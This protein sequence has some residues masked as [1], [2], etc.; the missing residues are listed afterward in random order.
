[1]RFPFFRRKAENSPGCHIIS[2]QSSRLENG[3][4]FSLTKGSEPVSIPLKLSLEEFRQQTE[5][6][7][8]ELLEDLWYE[9]WLGEDCSGY[10]LPYHYLYQLD[11]RTR[12]LLHLPEESS[13]LQ[14]ALGNE[15][16]IP[17]ASFRFILEK[18]YGSWKHLEKTA[19]QHGPLITLPDG[20]EILM[21]EQQYAFDRFLANPPLFAENQDLLRHVAQ[22][23]SKAKQLG[24][25]C[26]R[27]LA[28]QDYLFVDDLELEAEFNG[29][30]IKLKPRYKTIDPVPEEIL[31]EMEESSSGFALG[32][33][34]QKIFTHPKVQAEAQTIRQLPV[35]Q[36]TDI[37][38]FTE[39][40]D[41]YLPELEKIDL[42]R[43]G[44][45]VKE[46]G[47][48]IYRAQPFVNASKNK[49]NWFELSAGF[50]T[51][52][53]TGK[54]FEDLPAQELE[55]LIQQARK[56][57]EEYV[58][59]N[60]N[61]IKVPPQAEEFIRA[62]GELQQELQREPAVDIT[63]LPYV[64]EIFDN[65]SQLEFNQPILEAK[66]QLV[67]EGILAP[68]PP[69]GFMANL[70]PFQTDGFIWMKSLHYRHLGGLLADD[71]GLGKTI[72]VISFLTFLQKKGELNPTLIV[73]PKTLIQNWVNEIR[74]FAPS[75]ASAVYIHQKTGRLKDARM[76]QKQ[77]IV[78]TTYHTLT[79]DQ[80][81]LGQVDWKAVICDEA[82]AIKNPTT[83]STK[84]IKALK[85][86]FRLAMTGT[87]VENGLSELWSIVDF[88]QPGLLGSLKQFRTD[89]IDPLEKQKSDEQAIEQKLARHISV[90][91]KR[92]TRTGNPTPNKNTDHKACPVRPGP[93]PALP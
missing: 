88:V 15:G 53:E 13:N 93:G 52:D 61:W 68:V 14:L 50:H 72:Q 47:I 40:P 22:V 48:R 8:L 63:K 43:F 46:L 56:H 62:T 90:I 19:I 12:R 91:Y 79:R 78:L 77:G 51:V 24:I 10:I 54:I 27:Y 4:L 25:P 11:T 36:G 83:A 26:N 28:R 92:R 44:E 31:Q 81:L 87:P 30:Q 75:L 85:T 66:K 89:F 38:K 76:I 35:I 3:I 57:E 59:W 34:K 42:A 2:I 17:S 33:H 70:K 20:E 18:S 39:N 71:M 74:K 41:A 80:L 58:E 16:F 32:P 65:F 1:M 6:E 21:D 73:V 86:R 9:E 64:L 37:P 49:R 7:K 69:Q 29:R 45:R 67:D 60:N 84:V 5:M 82:Q 55:Q 23:L